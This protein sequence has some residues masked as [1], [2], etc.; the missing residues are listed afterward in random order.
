MAEPPTM[1]IG[2][3]SGRLV[4]V[5]QEEGRVGSDRVWRSVVRDF[6]V[7]KVQIPIALVVVDEVT[8]HFFHLL[9]RNRGLPVRLRMMSGRRTN[10]DLEDVREGFSKVGEEDRIAVTHHVHGKAVIPVNMVVEE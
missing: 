7:D 3:D 6:D 10:L 5:V 8:P 4:A 9:V 2:R 1:K